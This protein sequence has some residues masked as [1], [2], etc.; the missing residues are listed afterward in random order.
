MAGLVER[1]PAAEVVAAAGLGGVVAL[2]PPAGTT[3]PRCRVG[4]ANNSGKWTGEVQEEGLK[5]AVG[6][7]I[8]ASSSV[9]AD[10]DHGPTEVVGP[11]LSAAGRDRP[12]ASSRPCDAESCRGETL[13]GI[14]S[15]SCPGTGPLVP[16]C[17]VGFE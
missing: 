10:D 1:V 8:S 3:S 14:T 6:E 4:V 5:L 7:A 9:S 16:S 13:H 17:E 12:A 15:D 2:G 11:E